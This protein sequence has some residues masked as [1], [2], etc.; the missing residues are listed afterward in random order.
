MATPITRWT[1]GA[2]SID[3]SAKNRL[4]TLKK[5]VQSLTICA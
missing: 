4:M 5:N 1:W 3:F 2:N